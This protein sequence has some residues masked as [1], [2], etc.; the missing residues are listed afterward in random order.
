MADLWRFQA[1]EIE[2]AGILD[3]EE[4][5]QLEAEKRVLANAER[6]YAAAMAAQELLYEAE[7]SAETMLGGALKQVEEL[8]QFEPNLRR[9][10]SSWRR[11]RRAWRMWRRRCGILRGR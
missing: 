9:R 10:R 3:A 4:D 11:R 8:A 7:V 1:K 6:L 5:V 2:A